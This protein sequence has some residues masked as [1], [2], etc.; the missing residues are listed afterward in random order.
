MEFIAFEFWKGTLM[1]YKAPTCPIRGTSAD[2]CG[3]EGGVTYAIFQVFCQMAEMP[4]SSPKCYF[5]DRAGE[6]ETIS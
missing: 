3:G 1:T 5:N 4:P 2:M 6:R